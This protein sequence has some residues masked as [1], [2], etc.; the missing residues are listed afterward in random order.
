MLFFSD[1]FVA[2]DRPVVQAYIPYRTFLIPR[3]HVRQL[4]RLRPLIPVRDTLVHWG[5]ILVCWTA[6]VLWTH[7]AIVTAAIIVIGINVY[8]LYIIA[9]DGLHRR[10]FG[11]PR[12]N[13]F[14]NDAMIVGSFG[15]ITRLNRL[16]HIKHH[17]VTCLP[18]DPDR[19]KYAHDGKEPFF[20]FFLFLSGLGN[21]LPT[22]RN[23]FLRTGPRHTA[24]IPQ[25]GYTARD[26]AILAGWQGALVVG[27]TY[28][29]GWWPTRCCG[30]CQF[31]YSPIAAT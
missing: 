22:A 19:H 14:W 3:E 28:F 5:F 31:I 30:C 1:H 21:L 26:L 2:S 7:P 11:D 24:A 15:A 6:V 27:L 12:H 18:D 20:P 16:N 9:H 23:V 4:S 29:V 10:L 17:L 25:D 8:G 13:D